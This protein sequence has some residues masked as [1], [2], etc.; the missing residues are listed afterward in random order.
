MFGLAIAK[1]S[2]SMQY[3]FSPYSSQYVMTGSINFYSHATDQPASS[4]TQAASSDTQAASSDTLQPSVTVTAKCI[5]EAL[6]AV[7]DMNIDMIAIRDNWSVHNTHA[8]GK[9]LPIR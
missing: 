5:R 2:L 7:L 3:Q 8:W 1:P 4:D 6:C 9:G